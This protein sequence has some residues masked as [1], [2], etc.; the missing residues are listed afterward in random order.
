VC[1]RPLP[2]NAPM[3]LRAARTRADI[4]VYSV[5]SAWWS[6]RLGSRRRG[7][8]GCKSASKRVPL[9]SSAVL[10]AR[11]R[12]RISASCWQG[13]QED[14]GWQM[15]LLRLGTARISSLPGRLVSQLG[16]LCTVGAVVHR[17]VVLASDPV[18][19]YV[20]DRVAAVREPPRLP[21]RS[22]SRLR[23][24]RGYAAGPV[25]CRRRISS[26]TAEASAAA[27]PS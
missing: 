12:L 18:R 5:D 22:A 15:R 26:L 14:Y 17:G 23:R 9:W 13:R 2:L 3:I 8:F 20:R 7:C 19:T 16:Y 4:G 1:A 10:V 24:G 21:P 25:P 6:Q 27:L 11:N